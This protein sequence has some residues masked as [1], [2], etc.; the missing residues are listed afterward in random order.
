MITDE[1]LVM[2]NYDKEE[3]ILRFI[4]NNPD[5]LNDTFKNGETMLHMAADRGY[6]LLTY[7][8]MNERFNAEFWGQQSKQGHSAETCAIASSRTAVLV[9]MLHFMRLNDKTKETAELLY[10]RIP[11]RLSPEAY[12]RFLEIEKNGKAYIKNIEPQI[13]KILN[14]KPLI[15]F[16]YEQVGC[17]FNHKIQ[18]AIVEGREIKELLLATKKNL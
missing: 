6:A 14:A 3:K 10:D 17:L 11:K 4:H 7:Y 16:L 1:L 12:V 18:P 15:T 2:P 5:R 9:V 13:Q 8:I